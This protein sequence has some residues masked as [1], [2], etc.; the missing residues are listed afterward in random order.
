MS[1]KPK[2]KYSNNS[3]ED[4]KYP[5]PASDGLQFARVSQIVDMGTQPQANIEEEYDENN[6]KHKAAVENGTGSFTVP[7]WGDL[8][9]KKCI[10][11][12]RKPKDSVAVFIDLVENTVD[13]GGEIG[14]KHYRLMLNKSFKG[15]ITPIPFGAVPPKSPDG[16]WTFAPSSMLTKLA[17]VCNMPQVIGKGTDDEN[18]D[19]SLLLNKPLQVNIEIVTTEKNGKTFTN[20]YNKGL[21]PIRKTDVVP[22]LLTEARLITFDEA[23]AEDV[24]FIRKD[25]R[26]KIMEA[27]NFKGSNMEKAFI[28]AGIISAEQASQSADAPQEEDIPDVGGDEEDDS[29]PF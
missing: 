14:E 25:L 3:N 22:E 27:L 1:F 20:V 6:E 26:N 24:K 9:G 21:S 16:K 29:S 23:T 15:D 18:M 8:K 10:S 2:Q 4:R 19:I 7:V 12:P 11:L 28:A 17:T 13:Y 5:A